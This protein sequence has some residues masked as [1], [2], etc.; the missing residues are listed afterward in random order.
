MNVSKTGWL[1]PTNFEQLLIIRN[2]ELKPP[3]VRNTITK[4]VDE[5]HAIIKNSSI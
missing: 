2:Y 1:S 5:T 3:Q 4:F